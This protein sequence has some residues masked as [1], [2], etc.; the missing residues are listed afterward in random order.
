MKN[1]GKKG[2]QTRARSSAQVR[3]KTAPKKQ[4]LAPASAATANPAAKAAPPSE[5]KKKQPESKAAPPPPAVPVEAESSARP[6]LK[7]G[8]GTLGKQSLDRA[9]PSLVFIPA[10]AAPP[11]AVVTPTVTPAVASGRS[12]RT[13]ELVHLRD[14]LRTLLALFD[15]PPPGP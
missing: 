6:R 7:R 14:E 5:R 1:Q 8:L 4:P 13:E 15:E 9:L 10:M 2:R 12:G 3:K 11:P